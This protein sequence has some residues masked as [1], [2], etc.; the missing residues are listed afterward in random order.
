MSVE[1]GLLTFRGPDGLWSNFR[2]EALATPQ[3]FDHDPVT[4]WAWYRWRRS[5]LAKRQPH[6][7]H[8]VLAAWEAR[9]VNLTIVTQNV[10][11][12]HHRAGSKNIIELHGRLDAAR[13]TR[14]EH[15]ELGLHDLGPDPHCPRCG[16]RLRPGVVWFG[17]ILPPGAFEAAY[18]AA[19]QSDAFL[20]IGTSGIVQPAASLAETAQSA[21]G[22]VIEINPNPTPVSEIADVVIRSG[23]RDALVAIDSA[24]SGV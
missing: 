15:R 10:D 23:C 4:V 5:E 2:P 16:S 19:Q 8:R 18:F 6:E 21:G 13:C 9:G 24:W 20:V 3:A 17:E 7:G 12:L 22:A 11:G 14:C 1:S